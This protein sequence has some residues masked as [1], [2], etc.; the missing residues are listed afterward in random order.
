MLQP[1]RGQQRAV[2]GRAFYAV[3]FSAPTAGRR[4]FSG[5]LLAAFGLLATTVCAQTSGA[6]I[7][8][9]L[10]NSQTL[11]EGRNVT[12]SVSVNGTAPFTYQWRKESTP[13]SGATNSTLTL[14][15]IRVAD[16][17]SYTV[18]VGNAAGSVISG[19]IILAVNPAVAPSFSYQQ[20]AIN[21]VVGD[22][23]QFYASASGTEPLTYVWKQGSTT[24]ATTTS[25]YYSKANAQLVDAGTYTVAASNVAGSATSSPFTVTVSPVTAPVFGYPLSDVTVRTGNYFY[26]SA[27]LSGSGVITYQWKKDGVA[28]TGANSSYFSKSSAEAADAGSYTL[29]ATNSAGSTTSNA[30]RVT[31]LPPVAP[32]IS[33]VSG[34]V[35]VAVGESFSLSVYAEGNGPFSFQWS[36]DG[37]AIAGATGAYYSKSAVQLSDAGAYTV[38]VSNAQGSATSNTVPVSVTN[39]KPPVITYHPASIAVRQGD[40]LWEISVGA[41]GTGTLSYQWSKNGTPIPGANS[42][43]YYFSGNAT[44]AHAGT[45][46]VVVSS[47][48]GSVTSEPCYITVLPPTPPVIADQPASQ[49]VRQG[50]TL[51]LSGSAA[52]MPYPGIQWRKDAVNIPGA[53]NTSYYESNIAS[54]D[55]GAYSFTATNSAGTATSGNAIIT[56]IAATPPRIIAHP[57]SASLLPGESFSGMYVE[58]SADSTYT[59]Q[60]YLNGQAIPWA[61]STYYSI[62]NAQPSHAGTYTTVVTSSAGAVTSREAVITVD[63]NTTRPVITFVQG[64]GRSRAGGAFR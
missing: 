18:L 7:I 53:T 9:S 6:P 32:T 1:I 47:T 5:L 10:S 43:S 62:Y 29:T 38:V 25:N 21:V 36:K 35:S 15:P 40:H 41:S 37:Q 54:S 17:G 60:W 12:L 42:S 34:A 51:S 4:N 24:V 28:I 19:P 16:A 11:T 56:V 61:T 39:A 46:T 33:S 22:T 14:N 44:A 50:Q 20:S 26:L 48:Q 8:A 59:V 58:V 30:A 2:V 64:A 55:A 13:I 57:A 3:L 63:A 49:T 23:L 31:V 27:S 45:Y 52:G